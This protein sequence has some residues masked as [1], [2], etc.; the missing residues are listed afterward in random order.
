MSKS[1]DDLVKELPQHGPQ[2]D[3][4]QG[5]EAAIVNDEQVQPTRNSGHSSWLKYSSM[6]ASVCLAAIL[7]YTLPQLNNTVRGKVAGDMLAVLETQHNKQKQALL[8]S[9]QNFP[10]AMDDWQTQLTELEQAADAI[11]KALEEDPDNTA[12][13]KMLQN[14][15]Q[16]QID[17]IETVHVS[18]WQR[19]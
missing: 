4:W 8:V 16:Q 13:L 7:A 5:I 10:V 17:L 9:Y 6:A 2:R 14:V 19:I 18:R 11:K 3:L 1:I 15:Y 12:L